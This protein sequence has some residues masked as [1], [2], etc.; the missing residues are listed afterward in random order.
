MKSIILTKSKQE[1]NRLYKSLCAF[2]ADFINIPCYTKE[3]IQEDYE[4][5]LDCEFVFS[6]WYMPIFTEMEVTKYFP[7]LK[8]IFY[9]AGAAKYF[10]EPFLKNGVRVFTAASANGIP[11]AE[12]TASQIILA[13]KGY[14][15]AQRAYK[16]PIWH[17]GYRMSRAFSERKY[18]NYG[19]SIGIIGCGAIGSKVIKLLSQYQLNVYVCDPFLSDDKATDLGVKKVSIEELF[20][21]CDVISN[22]LPDI[23]STKK[24]INE[25]LLS[26]MKPTAT[27][28]NTG[29]GAQIDERALNRVLKK[30][31]NMCALLDVTSHEPLFPWSPLYWRKNVF[32]SPHI[33]GSLSKEY[34]R[35]VE[36]MVQAYRDVRNMQKNECE[37][38]LEIIKNQS[39]H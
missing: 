11:V 8:F 38:T 31:K 23:P 39:N 22:H 13:S 9:A 36:Y 28:I 6:S 5:L 7:S 30:H 18:G 4:N 27:I 19:A 35:M 32:L 14:F 25:A 37:V 20:S 17:K 29:R 24:I 15:Q 1:G 12:F 10:A 34:E 33:A 2:D 3:E 21:S 16:W 26:S